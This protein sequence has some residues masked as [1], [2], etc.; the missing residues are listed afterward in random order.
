VFPGLA[1]AATTLPPGVFNAIVDEVQ[2]ASTNWLAIG[3]GKLVHRLVLPEQ[4]GLLRRPIANY[5]QLRK[6]LRPGELKP[7]D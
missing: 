2:S 3:A 1:Q 6:L 5:R 4:A 7:S